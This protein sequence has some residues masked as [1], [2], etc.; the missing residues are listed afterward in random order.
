MAESTSLEVFVKSAQNIPNVDRP[1]GNSDPFV[2]ITFQGQKKQTKWFKDQPN[3]EWNESLIWDLREPLEPA[4]QLKVVVLDHERVGWPQ[5]I[6]ETE[7]SLAEVVQS[8]RKVFEEQLKD[9]DGNIIPDARLTMEIKYHGHQD[10]EEGASD[11]EPDKKARPLM[12]RKS[13]RKLTVRKK[14][15]IVEPSGAASDVESEA[16]TED[17]EGEGHLFRIA[18]MAEFEKSEMRHSSARANL[19]DKPTD[20]Q[21]RV[22]IVEGRKLEGEF[23]KAMAKVFIAGQSKETPV[24]QGTSNPYWNETMIFNFKEHPDL[25]M[26]KVVE[27]RVLNTRK[28][29]K[30]AV[31]GSFKFDVGLAYNE[32]DHCFI[33]KW[34]LLTDPEDSSSSAKGYVKVSINVIGPGDEPKHSPATMSPD[35]VDIEA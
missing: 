3:P 5:F 12:R 10:G 14:L 16:D 35:N 33:H 29:L 21:I 27:I 26:D 28:L 11:D 22:H 17:V 31:I 1:G 18:D 24:R 4:E 13:S 7:V 19:P 2:A 32:P 20:F 23:L 8:G 9:K 34:L 30:D 6:G 15:K 25:M